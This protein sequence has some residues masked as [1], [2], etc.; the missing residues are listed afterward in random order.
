MDRP[1]ASLI[2]HWQAAFELTAL[3][4]LEDVVRNFAHGSRYSPKTGEVVNIYDDRAVAGLKNVQTKYFQA[5][6]F[7]DAPRQP[8]PLLLH[9]NG[10]A[11]HLHLGM[12]R[13]FPGYRVNI[14]ADHI[15]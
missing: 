15:Q 11:F 2:G 7:A 10:V 12:E 3:S 14:P 13:G 4:E 1:Q 8:K 6:E 9:G 5:G